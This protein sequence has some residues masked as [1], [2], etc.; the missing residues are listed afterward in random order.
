MSLTAQ[1]TPRC[2]ARLGGLGLGTA[3]AACTASHAPC[4]AAH[5]VPPMY[6][7]CHA[8]R[9]TYGYEGGKP[10]TLQLLPLQPV[11]EVPPEPATA[12]PI[13]L[14]V[15]STTPGVKPVVVG[16][17]GEWRAQHQA[18]VWVQQ[19]LWRVSE[20]EVNMQQ[21]LL[22][23]WSFGC[24]QQQDLTCPPHQ[25]RGCGWCG[26]VRGLALLAE[27]FGSVGPVR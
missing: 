11:D 2:H 22:S 23:I 24:L 17:V 21:A 16:V 26:R 14:T 8:C 7:L 4:A 12:R 6:C 18:G 1:H 20:A 10:T 19:A 15:I 25:T 5:V 3:C 13:K 9:T 27:G